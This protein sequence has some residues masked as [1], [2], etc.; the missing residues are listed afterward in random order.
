MKIICAFRCEASCRCGR[1]ASQLLDVPVRIWSVLRRA[2]IRW[3]TIPLRGRRARDGSVPEVGGSQP[4]F[5]SYL[6]SWAL[7]V[8]KNVGSVGRLAGPGDPADRGGAGGAST[9]SEFVDDPGERT[10]RKIAP[11]RARNPP[12]RISLGTLQAD[13]RILDGKGHTLNL[14]IAL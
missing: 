1:L 10:G 2:W 13:L 9:P 12:A 3:A 5:F 11:K 7:G 8:S 14:P 4:T 6:R